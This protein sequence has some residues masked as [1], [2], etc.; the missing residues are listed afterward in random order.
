M[1]ISTAGLDEGLNE[2]GCIIPGLGDAETVCR[3]SLIS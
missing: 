1:L 2:H 3:Y